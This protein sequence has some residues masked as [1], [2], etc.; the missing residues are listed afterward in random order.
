MPGN[1]HRSFVESQTPHTHKVPYNNSQHKNPLTFGAPQQ[2]W[3][4]SVPWTE[5][6]AD[7]EYK[8]GISNFQ[9]SRRQEQ[10]SDNSWPSLV[11]LGVSWR[12][13]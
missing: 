2:S 11:A 6:R 8:H 9:L 3:S 7:E 12:A 4:V 5:H 13:A 10:L 1:T